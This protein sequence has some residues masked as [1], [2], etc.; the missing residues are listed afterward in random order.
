M[1]VID[2]KN[3]NQPLRTFKNV[4]STFECQRYC[5]IDTNCGS[6][7]HETSKERCDLQREIMNAANLVKDP[8]HNE[9]EYKVG[10]KHCGEFNICYEKSFLNHG[11]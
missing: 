5:H 3:R 9:W 6:F 7:V 1:N 11:K 2:I 4:K 8:T 10:P